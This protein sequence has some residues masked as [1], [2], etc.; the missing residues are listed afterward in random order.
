MGFVMDLDLRRN[1]NQKLLEGKKS[2]HVE[3]WDAHAIAWDAHA[4]AWDAHAIAWDAHAIVW[5]F[6]SYSMENSMLECDFYYFLDDFLRN[7]STI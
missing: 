4:I 2:N 6:S 7:W 1:K 5:T 3:A